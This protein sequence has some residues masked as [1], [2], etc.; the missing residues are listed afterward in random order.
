MYDF[1]RFTTG[2]HINIYKNFKILSND[3]VAGILTSF[4]WLLEYIFT[5]PFSNKTI[6]NIIKLFTR[7]IFGLIK[8]LDYLVRNKSIDS[9]SCT[10]LTAIKSL[11]ITNSYKHIINYYNCFKLITH[12]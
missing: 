11:N 10:Y 5:Q 2:R 1:T 12:E 8:Y 9:A 7:I 4:Y 3:S 6:R